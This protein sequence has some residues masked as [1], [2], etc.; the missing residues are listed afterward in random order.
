MLYQVVEKSASPA[1]AD[2]TARLSALG[3]GG[4][5]MS[6]IKALRAAAGAK[7]AMCHGG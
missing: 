2:A 5:S 1:A 6:D 3:Q 4:V 7:C